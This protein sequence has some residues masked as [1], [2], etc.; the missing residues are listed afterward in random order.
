MAPDQPMT[1]RRL[2]LVGV[3]AG[4]IALVIRMI[5]ALTLERMTFA[6]ALLNGAI[7]FVGTA[8]ATIIIALVFMRA[9]HDRSS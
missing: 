1:T 5:F 4:A 3:E 9:S 7:F 8:V 6:N 2:L